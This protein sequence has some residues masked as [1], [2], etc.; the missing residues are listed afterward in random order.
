MS[1]RRVSALIFAFMALGAMLPTQSSAQIETRAEQPCRPLIVP[2]LDEVEADD[3]D[4]VELLLGRRLC[5][6]DRFKVKSDERTLKVKT[7]DLVVKEEDSEVDVTLPRTPAIAADPV[8]EPEEIDPVDLARQTGAEIKQEHTS[9]VRET[10][11]SRHETTEDKTKIDGDG[12]SYKSDETTEEIEE[13]DFESSEEE[14][15]EEFR[16]RP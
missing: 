16:T 9:V 5:A 2:E 3:I 14:T 4:L 10:E 15:E 7:P 11:D 8:T 13:P 1:M 12:F 6:G